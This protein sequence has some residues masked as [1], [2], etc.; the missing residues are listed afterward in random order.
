MEWRFMSKGSSS[1]D[2]KSRKV[3]KPF[4]ALYIA[5]DDIFEALETMGYMDDV[6]HII[7]CVGGPVLPN[8]GK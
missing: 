6:R 7:T 1:F 3:Q 5:G 8:N 4:T 2:G